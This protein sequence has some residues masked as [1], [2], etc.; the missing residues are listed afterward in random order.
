M[1][2]S[3]C[4]KEISL[5]PTELTITAVERGTRLRALLHTGFHAQKGQ[6]LK[7]G[8]PS[9]LASSFAHGSSTDKL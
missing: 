2:Q 1:A 4:S 7:A 8:V 6:N 3:I 9:L 5:S